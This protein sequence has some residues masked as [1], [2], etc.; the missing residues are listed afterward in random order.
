MMGMQAASGD[1]AGVADGLFTDMVLPCCRALSHSRRRELT[2][3]TSA[4][5]FV[6]ALSSLAAKCM[7]MSRDQLRSLVALYT[8]LGIDSSFCELPSDSNVLI[9]TSCIASLAPE[10]HRN[11]PVVKM[12]ILLANSSMLVAATGA[13]SL[14]CG[15]GAAVGSLVNKCDESVSV[16]AAT[17]AFD[18]LYHR[19]STQIQSDGAAQGLAWI[20][21]LVV[22]FAESCC[23]L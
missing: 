6:I 8:S 11:L 2:D 22:A 14:C 4:G 7:R 3:E 16:S 21:R 23:D 12:C 19:A 1:D 17:A 13:K 20:V 15:A 9:V 18:V 10:T 5:S